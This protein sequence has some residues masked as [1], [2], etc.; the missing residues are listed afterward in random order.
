[1]PSLRYIPSGREPDRIVAMKSERHVRTSCRPQKWE[2][3]QSLRFARTLPWN[4]AVCPS[5]WMPF[6]LCERTLELLRPLPMVWSGNWTSISTSSRWWFSS[7]HMSITRTLFGTSFAQDLRQMVD[8]Q[9][10][11]FL[12][13]G[14]VSRDAA[15][16]MLLAP[17]ER[18]FEDVAAYIESADVTASEDWRFFEEVGAKKAFLQA[19]SAKAFQRRFR[20]G[21]IP[22]IARPS[23]RLAQAF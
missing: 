20:P 13:K 21:D 4:I 16:A 6:V 19:V 2:G 14:A 9:Y 1:M 3:R 17:I 7:W 12:E 8:R 23:L 5:P 22:A 15:I 18:R 10:R 11:R